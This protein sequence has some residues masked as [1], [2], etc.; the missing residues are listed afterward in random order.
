MLSYFAPKGGRAAPP[1]PPEPRP[2]HPHPCPAPPSP[3]HHCAPEWAIFQFSQT[4]PL[5]HDGAPV[6]RILVIPDM[7]RHQC[8][9]GIGN[10]KR[11]QQP[12]Q[13]PS[14]RQL[15]C[16]AIWGGGKTAAGRRAVVFVRELIGGGREL[17]RA[18]GSVAGTRG[19]WACW[20]RQE[21][22]PRDAVVLA[23]RLK[24]W[25]VAGGCAGWSEE[26]GGLGR[27]TGLQFRSWN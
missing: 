25:E 2:V 21:R 16:F 5:S 8:S 4:T 9:C 6:D 12:M 27:K 11:I 19:G 10:P 1:Q 26:W 17:G 22:G 7:K 18:C 13:S 24:Q 20:G 23:R 3:C 14:R 15:H